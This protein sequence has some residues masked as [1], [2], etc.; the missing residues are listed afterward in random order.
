MKG[1]RTKLDEVLTNLLSNANKFSPKGSNIT[2]RAKEIDNRVIVEVEDSAPAITEEEKA[3]LFAPYYRGED[4]DKRQRFPGVGL[5][6]AISKQLV[7]L[8]QGEIWV[9]SE[10]EKGNTF[11]FSL[12]AL[13]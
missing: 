1:E 6:L 4:A 10:D 11:S 8:H 2:L 12:P 5:G 9:E 7:E 3:N 13:K